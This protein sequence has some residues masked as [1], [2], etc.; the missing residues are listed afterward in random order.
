MPL[1]WTRD[2]F[3][4]SVTQSGERIGRHAVV[5]FTRIQLVVMA[6]LLG[7]LLPLIANIYL[8]NELLRVNPEV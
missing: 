5:E 8:R 2:A 3:F 1:V 7:T 6:Y 4:E